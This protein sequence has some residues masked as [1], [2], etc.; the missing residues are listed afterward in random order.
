M[1]AL[2]ITPF[3]ELKASLDALIDLLRAEDEEK[4]ENLAIETSVSAYTERL[5]RVIGHLPD[6]P[7]AIDLSSDLMDLVALLVLLKS[8]RLLERVLRPAE[9]AG[10]RAQL[11]RLI[12]EKAKALRM[13]IDA[14]WLPLEPLRPPREYA[15]PGDGAPATSG[16]PRFE[17]ISFDEIADSLDQ[18]LAEMERPPHQIHMEK[19]TV[20]EMVERLLAILRERAQIVLQRVWGGDAGG[21]VAAFLAV[22]D[23]AFRKKIR[24]EQSEPYAGVGIL[25]AE[26]S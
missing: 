18:V 16:G 14:R 22:L 26:M 5:M 11:M 10:A 8:T 13:E 9:D 21:R 25:R 24:I 1:T 20:E 23:L 15:A 17:W 7:G 6:A 2:A 3:V 12:R 19:P 4:R